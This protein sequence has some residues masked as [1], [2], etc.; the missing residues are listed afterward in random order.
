MTGLTDL[1]ARRRSTKAYRRDPIDADV[2]RDLVATVAGP[3]RHG[4]RG[5]GSAHARYD[6]H[7][8]VITHA[9]TGVAAAAYRYD[10]PLDDLVPVTTGDF[11]AA[12]ADATIDAD[13]LAD[14]PAALVL[15]ADTAAADDAFA[16]QG[17][18][19]G[20]RFCWIETGLIAQNVYLWAAETGFGTVLLGG[21]DDDAIAAAAAQWLPPG[22]IVTAVMPVGTV[23]H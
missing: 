9:V 22:H 3:S 12:V 2:L 15:S 17:K 23:P 16:D 14:C 1:L 21:V 4:R 7:I 20:T 10:Q 11:L 19:R 8:T 5:H 13:W 6:V 18:D